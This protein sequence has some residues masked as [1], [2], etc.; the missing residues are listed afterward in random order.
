M[1]PRRFLSRG[2][3]VN[4]G[5]G[6]ITAFV[7][8][9][10]DIND[11][12]SWLA[13]LSYL[14]SRAKDR[15]TGGDIFGGTDDIGIAS[16]IYK[17]APGGNPVQQNLVLAGEYFYGREKG[18]FDGVPINLSRN[19][20]YAQGVYQFMPRWSVGLRYAELAPDSIPGALTGSVLDDLG[21]TPRA[22]TGLVEFDTSEFGRFRLQYTH[23]QSDL[24]P[25]D[26]ILFQYTVTYGA[27]GAHRY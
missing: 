24:K 22:I 23:D 19:G 4:E 27:H 12:S 10:D 21:H 15:D 20:W 17:W 25:N 2:G 26:E 11:S 14:H 8:A 5:K 18:M 1:V 7:H 6:T 9:G 16:L 3:A 13:G